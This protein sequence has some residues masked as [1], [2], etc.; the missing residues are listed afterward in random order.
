MNAVNTSNLLMNL[1]FWRRTVAFRNTVSGI[2]DLPKVVDS[3]KTSTSWILNEEAA[4]LITS[5]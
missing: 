1:G 2:R 5:S 3:W 4:S